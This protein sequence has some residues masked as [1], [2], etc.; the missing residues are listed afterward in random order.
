MS[1]HL[2]D[3]AD[4]HCLLNKMLSLRC[5]PCSRCSARRPPTSSRCPSTRRRWRSAPSGCSATTAWPRRAGTSQGCQMA[6]CLEYRRLAFCAWGTDYG[7]ITLY[8]AKFDPFLTLECVGLE[9]KTGSNYAVCWHLGTLGHHSPPRHN[10]RRHRRPTQRRLP[11]ARDERTDGLELERSLKIKSVIVNWNY[12]LFF[13]NLIIIIGKV[14]YIWSKLFSPFMS[15]IWLKLYFGNLA[16]PMEADGQHTTGWPSSLCKTL[17]CLQNKSSKRPGQVRPK[18]NLCF[19]V[20][21]RFC[22]SCLVTLYSA[23]ERIPT[24]QAHIYL[25]AS[26][27]QAPIWGLNRLLWKGCPEGGEG[28]ICLPPFEV[29]EI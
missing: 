6:K 4:L 26:W 18:R 17:L 29:L 23:K 19:G 25:K 7:S 14:D 11:R 13:Q 2:P 28:R 20:N 21:G 5:L 3:S 16:E 27:L 9:G 10:L 8:T 15:V 22:L 1:R 24:S 12:L